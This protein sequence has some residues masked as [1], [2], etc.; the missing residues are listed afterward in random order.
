MATPVVRRIS[1]LSTGLELSEK[2]NFLAAAKRGQQPCTS[3]KERALSS[4]CRHEIGLQYTLD[5]A[6]PYPFRKVDV[7]LSTLPRLQMNQSQRSGND[8]S[9]ESATGRSFNFSVI[10][11]SSGHHRNWRGGSCMAASQPQCIPM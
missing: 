7:G 3:S 4:H 8:A 1:M 5:V 11:R 9:L 2:K 6:I 10:W